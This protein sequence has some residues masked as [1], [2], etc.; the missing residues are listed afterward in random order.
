MTAAT[1]TIQIQIDAKQAI[2]TLESLKKKMAE[3]V[4]VTEKLRQ[5]ASG[6]FDRLEAAMNKAVGA[7]DRMH[8]TM[9]S[10]ASGMG[11]GTAA[12]VRQAQ[13]MEKLAAAARAQEV[14][15]TKAAQANRNELADLRALESAKTRA[16]SLE[17]RL[18]RQLTDDAGFMSQRIV[19]Q[20]KLTAS[21]TRY[22]SVI[23]ASGANSAAG[24]KARGEL[25]RDY[26][27]ISSEVTR[28]AGLLPRLKGIEDKIPAKGW[29]SMSRMD[30]LQ[31]QSNA[32]NFTQ[33]T[34]ASGG[35]AQAL[36]VQGPE[37]LGL[38]ARYPT[39]LGPVAAGFVA[40]GGAIGVVAAA[41]G[42][43]S[44]QQ[45]N[46]RDLGVIIRATGQAG[47]LAAK[48]LAALSDR[49][50]QL[51]GVSREAAEKTVQN[52]ARIRGLGAAGVQGAAYMGAD[53]A[54]AIGE[55]DIA[56]ATAKLGEALANPAK[57]AREL[58]DALGFLS[59]GQLIS[60]ERMAAQGKRAEALQATLSAL[61]PHLEG[62]AS[63]G[64]S[65]LAAATDRL[66]NSFDHLMSVIANSSIIVGLM[67]R[68]ANAA[69]N[70]ADA[71][72][73]PGWKWVLGSAAL[74]NPATMPLAIRSLTQAPEPK[75]SLP[76]PPP[77]AQTAQ[78]AG[79]GAGV[80][81]KAP[82]TSDAEKELSDV[83]AL[84]DGYRSWRGQAEQLR[85]TLERVRRAQALTT[86]KDVLARLRQAE[87][88][89]QDQLRQAVDPRAKMV[90]DAQ[91]GASQEWKIAG[92]PW[93]DRDRMRV[94]IEAENTAREQGLSGLQREA[95]ARANLSSLA[96]K[97]LSAIQDSTRSKG[98]EYEASARL[99]DVDGM[100][101]VAQQQASDAIAKQTFARDALSKASNDNLAAVLAEIDGYDRLTDKLG[102]LSIASQ[103]RQRA[104]AASPTIAYNEAMRD[105]SG[106]AR[107]ME[108]MGATGEEIKRYYEDIELSKLNSSEN[109]LAGVKRANIDYQRSARDA[110]S[111]AADA[112]KRG[113]DSMESALT[114]LVMTGKAGFADLARSAIADMVRIQMR[115]AVVAPFMNWAGSA[116]TSLFGSAMGGAN[117]VNTPD[118]TVWTSKPAVT[119]EPLM[120][121]LGNAFNDNGI[122]R[123][124]KGSAFVNGIY[125]TPTL[126]KFAKGTQLGELGEAGPEAV[127]PLRRG[128]DGSLGV[129]VAGGGASSSAP[130]I[131]T[132]ISVNVEGSAS[133]GDSEMD[134]RQ[135]QRIAKAVDGQIRATV[136][137]ELQRQMKGGGM[138]NRV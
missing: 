107:Y 41:M 35:P 123:F 95:L 111:G 74:S 32:I 71:M 80:L 22:N 126:F 39:V 72:D 45:G 117:P 66:G 59:A 57:G 63:Q 53:F 34:I 2:V 77:L 89:L 38:M 23:A 70:V 112:F 60:I 56:K 94:A 101:I 127:M 109:W 17:S 105:A 124:A 138:L 90:L 55:Q 131:H 4:S 85:D 14:A 12:A 42:R 92:A 30:R 20:D 93:Q 47:T 82:G 110:A 46:L 49:I 122:A 97:S 135:A 58:N 68:M 40:V 79:G 91:R 78:A 1:S 27:G 106:T 26:A 108:D 37:L 44:E 132:E 84:S 10:M 15:Q 7:I 28:L 33:Q 61:K 121:K 134:E 125:N 103:F 98:Y 115:S 9:Q 96:A 137:S 73:G 6:G 118:T 136:V 67:E 114:N 29:A 21:V 120:N 54:R 52:L 19:L 36:M 88:G 62:L 102:Q 76:M 69:R 119:V 128:P 24:I 75:L 133:S 51:P 25:Q 65:P 31:L 83:L 13:A 16:F 50:N 99:V 104:R 129:M 130:V 100:G 116:L 5:V 113:A 18:N 81:A 48:D 86:D 3:N 11:A 64:M 87:S 43:L 8:A